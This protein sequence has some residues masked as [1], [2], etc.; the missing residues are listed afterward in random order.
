MECTAEAGDFGRIEDGVDEER[1]ARRVTWRNISASHHG[2]FPH[3]INL[4]GLKFIDKPVFQEEIYNFGTAVA[5]DIAAPVHFN[6]HHKV[7]KFTH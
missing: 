6:F 5:E 2:A 3:K 7:A 1:E 4:S